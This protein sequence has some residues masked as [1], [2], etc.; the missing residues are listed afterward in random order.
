MTITRYLWDNVSES[1]VESDVGVM[2]RS[3]DVAD[4][5]IRHRET[6]AALAAAQA[7]CREKDNL[8]TELEAAQRW[9]PCEEELP[10]LGIKSSSC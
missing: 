10:G 4:I 3:E 8:I 2:C 5:E 6:L 1:L 7:Q 9:I